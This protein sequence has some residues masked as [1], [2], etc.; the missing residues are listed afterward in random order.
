M[1]IDEILNDKSLCALSLLLILLWAGAKFRILSWTR[2]DGEAAT[3][4]LL[5]ISCGFLLAGASLDKL[6]DAG[7][8][9]GLI[10]ECYF[11]IPSSLQPL[12]AIVIPWLEFFTGLC[13]IF[14]F[15]WRSAAF[16]F[17]V[18]MGVY[19]L[20]IAWDVLHGID[21]S[22]GCFSK[23][24]AEKMSGWTVLRDLFFLGVGFIVLV[25]RRTFAALGRLND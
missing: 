1:K 19:T 11:F 14:G 5:R 24:T 22:C 20:A 18:L 7:G 6:G 4:T 16:V 15:R 25:S 3:T 12:T 10:K 13:L 2:W 23:N 8:F 9:L 21:C 17:C